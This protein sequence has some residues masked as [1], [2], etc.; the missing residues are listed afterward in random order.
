M[1]LCSQAIA[2]FTF[3]FIPFLVIDVP[4]PPTIKSKNTETL[5]CD[6]NVTWSTP[7]NNGCPLTKYSVYYRLIQAQET[8]ARWKKINITDVLKTHYV[9]PL[10]CDQQYLIEM[11]AW[12]EL[13]ESDR[14]KT[15][16]TKTISGTSGFPRTD[17]SGHV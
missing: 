16:I 11:S 17:N 10:R 1:E 12:N 15:W 3:N 6:A 14:S 7:L 5:S 13:G 9:L 2:L 8:G 4:W